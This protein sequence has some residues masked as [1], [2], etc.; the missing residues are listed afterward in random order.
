MINIAKYKKIKNNK[1]KKMK[2]GA[3]GP[4]LIRRRTRDPSLIEKIRGPKEPSV[5]F[6]NDDQVKLIPSNVDILADR[7]S[8]LKLI[9]KPYSLPHLVRTTGPRSLRF[10]R[11]STYSRPPPSSTRRVSLFNSSTFRF[12]R[13][14]YNLLTYIFNIYNKY[15]IIQLKLI[16]NI[17]LIFLYFNNLFLVF[18]KLKG[19]NKSEIICSL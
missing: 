17:K 10:Q 2:G 19:I 14:N 5:T 12:T 11:P 13:I 9:S 6:A 3:R 18:F 7:I 15:N 4:S 16:I 1:G 8:D